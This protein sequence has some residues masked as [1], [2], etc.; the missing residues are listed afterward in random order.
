[1]SG[2]LVQLLFLPACAPAGCTDAACAGIDDD[3]S[4]P[5][6]GSDPPVDTLHG[7]PPDEPFPAPAFELLNQY[8]ETR[9]EADLKGHATVLWFYPGAGVDW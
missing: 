9:T 1:M 2:L 3:T 6:T 5:D 7:D 8:S 4:T